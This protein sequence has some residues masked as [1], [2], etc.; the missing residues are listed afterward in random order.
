MEYQAATARGC[1]GGGG[2]ELARL[3]KTG[4][5]SQEPNVLTESNEV[6]R[7]SRGVRC[8]FGVGIRTGDLMGFLGGDNVEISFF[9]TNFSLR[10][11]FLGGSTLESFPHDQYSS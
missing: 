9:T 7:I 10:W 11:G 3:G 8:V 2:G 6:F 1:L 4:A 5:E